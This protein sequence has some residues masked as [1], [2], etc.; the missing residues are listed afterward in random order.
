MSSSLSFDQLLH[1][2][3]RP[4]WRQYYVPYGELHVLL[5]K[6]AARRASLQNRRSYMNFVS[7]T[8]TSHIAAVHTE[9][10]TASS[11]VPDI[12]TFYDLASSS[13]MF[14]GS[15]ASVDEYDGSRSDGRSFTSSR[16]R[17]EEKYLARLEKKEL[18][19]VLDEVVEK[20]AIFYLK[21]C[22]ELSQWLDLLKEGGGSTISG[23]HGFTAVS[24]SSLAATTSNIGDVSTSADAASEE[25]IRLG[26]ELLELYA[27]VGVNLTALRQILI[28]YDYLICALNGAPLGEWYMN[29]RRNAAGKKEDN[30]FE[31]IVTRRKL[32]F[33]SDQITF[34]V[35]NID[36]VY[37]H[38]FNDQISQIEMNIQTTEQVVDVAVGDWWA[39]L[40]YYFLAGSLLSDLLLSPRFIRARETT[41][42]KY[43]DF[44][45]R[46]RKRYFHDGSVQNGYDPRGVI[47]DTSG[48]GPRKL[49]DVITTPIILNFTAHLLYMTGHYIVEPTSLKYIRHLGGDDALASTLV[50][51]VPWAALISSFLYSLWSNRSFRQPLLCS[52]LFLIMG[53]FTYAIALEFHSVWMAMIG[54]F[55]QGLGAPTVICVRHISD[56]VRS[57]DRTAVSAILVTVG[58]LGMSFGPGLAV[59]LDFVDSDV[60]IPMLGTFTVNG[61]TAPGYLMFL[62]WSMYYFALIVYFS[63][64][65][66]VGLLEKSHIAD[67]DDYKPPQM[68]RHEEYLMDQSSNLSSDQGNKPN[69]DRAMEKQITTDE[70]S[71]EKEKPISPSGGIM[72][73]ATVVCMALKFIGKF[74]LEILA[75]SISLITMNRYDW[76]V[77]NIGVLGFVNGCLIMPISTLVGYLSHYHSDV[78]LLRALLCSSLLGTLLLI[79][80]T[81]FVNESEGQTYNEGQFGAIGHK[82]YIFGMVLQFCSFQAGQ[83]VVLSMM[84]KVVPLTLAKG[85]FN[86]G[87]ISTSMATVSEHEN[88]MA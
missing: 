26:R 77:R 54:R 43:I 65:E 13:S 87:F 67:E 30:L 25:Y 85:T 9:E 27:F 71:Q 34:F 3:E 76:S 75:C 16:L 46:W 28:H 50:G 41:L 61:M 14:S 81:D 62:F 20:I 84:S 22:E 48:S 63:D 64:E 45:A 23:D 5:E 32:T 33:M 51:M 35:T 37:G 80:V 11:P 60:Y 69:D 31:A 6:F 40:A 15:M 56:T 21:R 4:E 38:W 2:A 36:G 42:I 72:N 29:R 52:G 49:K 44:Y 73:E 78:V 70:S 79:D 86:S 88:K 1:S 19:H 17:E 53:S 47:L 58:A 59:L 24:S 68:L 57:A 12:E 39:S 18:C 55:L 8:S 66:R 10:D 74:I 83:S 82:R 7:C